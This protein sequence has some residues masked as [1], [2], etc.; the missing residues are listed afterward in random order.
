MLG[1]Q[2]ENTHG[3]SSFGPSLLFATISSSHHFLPRSSRTGRDPK[4]S[5]H[6]L[7]VAGVAGMVSC[8]MDGTA[9][10]VEVDD[11]DDGLFPSVSSDDAAAA[12]VMLPRRLEFE[13]ACEREERETVLP[14]TYACCETSASCRARRG[15]EKCDDGD[16]VDAETTT[17]PPRRLPARSLLCCC[18]TRGDT[19][20]THGERAANAAALISIRGSERATAAGRERERERE[21]ERDGRKIEVEVFGFL[22]RPSCVSKKKNHS[23]DRHSSNSVLCFLQTRTGKT[24]RALHSLSRSLRAKL[25]LLDPLPELEPA[26]EPTSLS[27]RDRREKKS[28]FFLDRLFP[29]SFSK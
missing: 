3:A 17:M 8:G 29:I 11:D 26:L 9:V 18:S 5:S 12:A 16:E 20:A 1:S 25:F 21:R 28:S 24:G 4:S 19:E 7:A 14:T 23:F 6:S 22:R 27:L 10:V 15:E 2:R 13:S